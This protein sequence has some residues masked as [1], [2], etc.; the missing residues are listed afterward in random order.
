VRPE[1]RFV[2]YWMIAYRRRR[3]NFALERAANEA[4][5]LRRPL[6][7][8]EA[9]RLDYPHASDRLHRFVIDGMAANRRDF[10]RAPILYHP[11]IERKRGA[12]RGLIETLA[13][14]ACLIVTD[15]YPC[16][17]VPRAV[18]AAASRVDV[19]VEA[20]D[21]N[22]LLPLRAT[23]H[24]FARAFDF[25][26]FL[27]RELPDHLL[28]PPAA[29]PLAAIALPRLD[30]LPREIE[31]RWPAA[32]ARELASP[33]LSAL[34]ID[35]EVTQVRD[36]RGGAT[37]ARKTLERFVEDGLSRYA[38]DRLD[39]DRPATSGL[40]PYLHFGH[41]GSH[42][43]LGA[44]SEREAF[45]PSGLGGPAGG[46]VR[47]WWGMSAGAEAFLDQL[48]AWRELGFNLSARRPDHDR[49]ES[50]PEWARRTLDAHEN[51]RRRPLYALHELEAAATH[52]TIWNAAQR[53]L[54]ETGRIHNYLRML[55]GKKILEW[56]PTPRRALERMIHLNDKYALDGRDPNSYSGICWCLGRYDRAWGP[57]RAIYGKV[58]YMSSES[59]RRK[60]RM[61]RYLE[62]FGEQEG[63]SS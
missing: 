8:L 52:D 63:Q 46:K 40:S 22:G 59:A 62:R 28:A 17:F 14:D 54:L 29:D 24:V 4:R 13:R 49:Y 10:T 39:L 44:V 37:A 41:I 43:V 48:V 20:V 42:Q 50:L 55:W 1:R 34:P 33:D 21:G 18:A 3:S 31:R 9:L 6:V 53:E 36:A 25:R 38:E 47:G 32:S 58:R 12:G 27:Q 26:R 2:L 56:S 51:D 45:D 60:L 30:A 7:V 61:K 35:H 16:F 5:R 11:W 15:D 19:R 57:E 23:D